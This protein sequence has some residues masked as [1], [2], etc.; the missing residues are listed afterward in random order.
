MQLFLDTAK[1][2]EIR[3]LCELGI[4]SGVTTNPSLLAKAGRP[5]EEIV[6]EI[7][8]LVGGSYFR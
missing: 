6:S 3:P 5:L 2:E 7:A 8:G 1:L 4:I